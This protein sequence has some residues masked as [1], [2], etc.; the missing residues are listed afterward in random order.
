MRATNKQHRACR[1]GWKAG[2]LVAGIISL[3]ACGGKK[4]GF[5]A[6]QPEPAP[7]PSAP[8]VQTAKP[9][10]EDQTPAFPEQTRAPEVSTDAT[11]QVNEITTR[12]N[13]P[14]GMA[15]LPDGRLLVTERPGTLRVVTQ[16]GEISAPV[17]GV[18]DVVS[19][20]QGGLLDV[21]LAP[22]FSEN[23]MVYL[24]FSEARGDGKNGTSVARGRLSD[25]EQRLEGV[26]VIFRQ[27]PP[28]D[29]NLHFGSR[30][31]W[32]RDGL[33]YVT[34]GERSH[35]EPRQLA[36]DPTTH[37]G[38]VVR[39]RPDGSAP[40]GNPFVGKEGA[41]E[42]W[43]LGHRNIQAAAL[44]P[45]TG[46]L[47]VVEHG[48]QGGDEINIPK[49]GKN[50]GWPVITY[51]EDYG[52]GPIGEGITK[53]EGM[54]Q[55]IYYWDPVIA[56]SGMTFYTGAMF[57]EWQGDLLVGSLN[58]GELVRL[59]LDGETV[60]G[61]E[62]L[63]PDVGRVRDVVQGPDGAVWLVTDGGKLLKVTSS[64]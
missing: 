54:E 19:A 15:F 23:R 36:Q 8:P 53:K 51:G 29:S 34:L 44:H 41:N 3:T 9:N 1:P 49:A 56:P 55:P 12:L 10:A 22:D 37:I 35:V 59:V 5:S 62:R 26:E 32:D 46:E 11:P 63:L 39:I 17:N 24:T 43:S 42:V 28:W 61:E 16:G 31:V 64:S 47:W 33:L 4:D 60:V 45:Q 25:D 6:A 18:P 57:E 14:W 52:G 50:Y 20:G 40:E 27:M 48:P 7:T 21:S 2:M 58:P 30:L 38:K 13:S